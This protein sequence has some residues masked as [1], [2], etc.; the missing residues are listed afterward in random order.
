MTLAEMDMADSTQESVPVLSGKCDCCSRMCDCSVMMA[1]E[2]WA[3][4]Q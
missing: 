3:F 1:G 4:M 2:A